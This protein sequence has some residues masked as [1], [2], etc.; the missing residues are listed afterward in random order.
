MRVNLGLFYFYFPFCA[1]YNGNIKVERK[2]VTLL[3][4]FILYNRDSWKYLSLKIK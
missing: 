2:S 4:P 1:A 3:Y